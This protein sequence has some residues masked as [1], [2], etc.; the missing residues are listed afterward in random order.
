VS[1]CL[2]VASRGSI[3]RGELINLVFWLGG[4]F[5]PAA[6]LRYVLRK[7]G[8]TKS[9]WKFFLNSGLIKF[10]HGISIVERAL[11]SRKVDAQRVIN[12]TVVGQLS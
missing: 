10:R 6:G 2:S 11:S 8:Y 1:V 7:F 9:L 3:K 12:W 5:Q 4:F